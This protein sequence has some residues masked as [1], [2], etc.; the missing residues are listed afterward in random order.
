MRTYATFIKVCK[1][2][3][4]TLSS[5]IQNCDETLNR[6]VFSGSDAVKK[7]YKRVKLLSY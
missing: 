7:M 4:Y 5:G 1:N 2:A 6:L 3:K